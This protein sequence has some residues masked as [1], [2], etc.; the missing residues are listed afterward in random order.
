VLVFFLY[1][2]GL[3]GP[4]LL[5][6]ENA[7]GAVL[8]SSFQ[9]DNIQQYLYSSTGPLG[10]TVS[11]ATFVANALFSTDIFYWKLVNVVLHVLCGVLIYFTLDQLIRIK[12]LDNLHPSKLSLVPLSIA[13]IWMLHPLHVS[14][15]L[16]LVQRMTQLSALFVLLGLLTYLVA[17]QRQINSQPFF[18]YQ[19]LTWGVCFPLGIFSKESALLFP[20]FIFLM[21]LFYLQSHKLSNKNMFITMTISLVAGVVFCFVQWERILGGYAR[22]EFSLVERLLTESRVLI[23]YLGMLLLPAQR[24]MGFYHDDFVISKSLLDPWTTLASL[25]SIFGLLSFA[26]YIRK[27]VPLAAFGI[28]FFF[29]AHL[30]EST[31][32]S[33]ELVFEHRNYLPSLGVFMAVAG[34]LQYYIESI[35]T[36]TVVFG[37][38]SVILLLITFVRVDTWSS[39]ISMDYYI[40]M[41]HPKSERMAS[42]LA[43]EWSGYGEY[44]LARKKLL[45]FNSLGVVIHRLDID[46]LERNTLTDE[47]FDI[48]MSS[49][50]V[51]DNYVVR[52]LADIANAGLDER[53]QFSSTIFVNFLDHVLSKTITPE[54][55]RQIVMIYKA[56][57]LWNLGFKQ[58]AITVSKEMYKYD[59][60]NPIPL[61]MACEWLLDLE[62]YKQGELVCNDALAVASRNMSQYVDLYRNVKQRLD[63]LAL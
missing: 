32:I 11:M 57:Y 8:T 52:G 37:V 42:K 24:N 19:V 22:R 43:S 25:L 61:F 63:A 26:F 48:D 53:C 62:D 31:I 30:L 7:L 47:K 5:D 46:C 55:N 6:D 15:V 38:S 50:R 49:Y 36:R 2:A 56:H 39:K 3:S 45:P 27:K 4:L 12:K 17:R 18:W 54:S 59:G 16:Y 33:L 21:E 9:Q 35:K 23:D 1:W 10:R 20:V 14:T 44:E 13:I 58:K 60:S 40:N 28:V 41:V 34:L 51:V 29:A